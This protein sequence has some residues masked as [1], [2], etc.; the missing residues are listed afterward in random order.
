MKRSNKILL[1]V[2]IV[3][4]LLAVGLFYLY[5]NLDRIVAAAIE[6]YGSQ[7]T[8]TKV[9]VSAVH[10]RLRA[11]EGSIGGLRV[12][13]PAGFSAPDAITLKNIAIS[14]DTSSITGNPIVIN[15]IV[16]SSPRVLYEVNGSGKSNILEIARH[17]RGGSQPAKEPAPAQGGNGTTRKVLIRSIVVERGE[18]SFRVAALPGKPLAAALPPIVLRNVGGKGGDS[19]GA[20]AE[21]VLV[22]IAR[23][24]AAAASQAGIQRYL[25]K[26]AEALQK[27]LEKKATKQ[28]GTRGEEAVH[29]AEN[30]IRNLLGQ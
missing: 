25:G 24:A 16:V 12:G 19:P 3:V 5:S 22:P 26:N 17:A 6:K 13:N 23:Q 8:G 15:R 30:T 21:Q 18:V 14:V 28:L 10:I 29:G 1:G 27:S 4:V 9:S 2:G 7:A 20:I 11:G